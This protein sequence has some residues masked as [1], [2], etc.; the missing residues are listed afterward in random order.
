MGKMAT[1]T[2]PV[3]AMGETVEISV[4]RLAAAAH[5]LGRR[6]LHA[7]KPGPIS[8]KP[9]PG[10]KPET[11]PRP[12][13]TRKALAAL[14][15]AQPSQ[16][17]ADGVIWASTQALA[18]ADALVAERDLASRVWLDTLMAGPIAGPDLGLCVLGPAANHLGQLW[19]DDRASFNQVTLGMWRLRR[20]YEDLRDALSQDSSPMVA[21][22]SVRSILLAAAPGE[23]HSFALPLVA[24]LFE[25]RDWFAEVLPN[26]DG[27]SLLAEVAA[28]PVD[29]V[30]L[31]VSRAD[32]M[33]PLTA[34][35]TQL[36]L[37]AVKMLMCWLPAWAPMQHLAMRAMP[38]IR[39]KP[40]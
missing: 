26:D 11:G 37:V 5:A 9:E 39:W 24:G 25:G 23:Q 17:A 38:W 28:R 2:R 1:E 4:G 19:L 22:A 13:R 35:I 14:Q 10:P 3:P 21:S 40:G 36:R 18:L 16:G 34:L 33:A 32:L 6:V 27:R 30:G 8:S 7:R 20:L 15:A 29:A 31:T 12:W